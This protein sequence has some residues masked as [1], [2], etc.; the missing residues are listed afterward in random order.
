M[1]TKNADEIGDGIRQEIVRLRAQAD[2]L[3]VAESAL[4]GVEIPE[5]LTVDQVTVQR[6][7]A[8]AQAARLAAELAEARRWILTAADFEVLAD[9]AEADV[10]A[11]DTGAQWTR[12]LCPVCRMLHPP[13][14]C[15]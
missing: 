11:P 1:G 5:A 10:S 7:E 12:R 4:L 2:A 15:P 3:E 6:D 8:R 9:E 13:G 14:P